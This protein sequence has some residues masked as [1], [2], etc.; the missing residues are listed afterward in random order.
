MAN[1]YDIPA[2]GPSMAFQPFKMN[3]E[4]LGKALLS[5]QQSFDTL[6]AGLGEAKT[7]FAG[8]TASEERDNR[9][10]IN[11]QKELDDFVNSLEGQDLTRVPNLQQQ[12]TA[13]STD[14]NLKIIE[15]N[16]AQNKALQETR[17]EY[18]KDFKY[19][20][21]NFGG[22]LKQK[23]E[24]NAIDDTPEMVS[25]ETPLPYYNYDEELTNSGKL[26]KATV[27]DR[28]ETDPIT[29]AVY[30]NSKTTLNADDIA[31]KL[32]QSFSKQAIQ[33]MSTEYEY[34]PD[35][36]EQF[37]N[38]SDYMLYM[39]ASKA[40]LFTQ[41]KSEYKYV[42][43]DN[44]AADSSRSSITIGNVE[45]D[46]ISSA[47]GSG[48][49][50]NKYNINFDK[51]ID[52]QLQNIV[53]EKTARRDGLGELIKNLNLMPAPNS[54]TGEYKFFDP[55]TGK[56]E[57]QLIES[58]YINSE[59]GED[60]TAEYMNLLHE[61]S[62]LNAE[63]Y[64]INNSQAE[65]K[66]DALKILQEKYKDNFTALGHL[67]K[68][69]SSIDDLYKLFPEKYNKALT[70][71]LKNGDAFGKDAIGYTKNADGSITVKYNQKTNTE[72]ELQTSSSTI[73][74]YEKT[75]T[76]ADSKVQNWYT[77]AEEKVESGIPLLKEYKEAYLESVQD[78][79]TSE[80]VT[81]SMSLFDM[82]D[83]DYAGLVETLNNS[84]QNLYVYS[85]TTGQ[86]VSGESFIKT[87]V[88]GNEPGLDS[89]SAAS[90][91][92]TPKGIYFN[93]VVGKWLVEANVTGLDKDG[94][95][96]IG[97]QSHS[98]FS[99][100][101][102]SFHN[103]ITQSIYGLNAGGV[104]RFTDM[105]VS[106]FNENTKDKIT[107]PIPAQFD[108]T[109]LTVYRDGD[110]YTGTYFDP[111]EGKYRTFT[112][113]SLPDLANRLNTYTSQNT[114]FTDAVRAQNQKVVV[115]YFTKLG[116][117]GIFPQEYLEETLALINHES[118]F[119]TNPSGNNLAA[120]L[121]QFYKDKDIVG[122]K[123][124]KTIGNKKWYLDD[125]RKMSPQEQ[126]NLWWNGYMKPWK[127]KVDK[128]NSNNG[129]GGIILANFVPKWLDLTPE[130]SAIEAIQY[131]KFD[132]KDFA[133]KN[134]IFGITRETTKTLSDQEIRNLLSQYTLQ[135]I[136][137]EV[138]TRWK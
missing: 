100:E 30:V 133:V 57:G 35:L 18:R 94:N 34:N 84:L 15:Y 127:V 29:G 95:R 1:R 79:F 41:S 72:S 76:N 24:Y 80:L 117:S 43:F 7:S 17:E 89:K 105:L 60:V 87:V 66:Q 102:D 125:I 137:D 97:N 2:S 135:D 65:A 129:N 58:A 86:K 136:V 48:F 62:A 27:E 44:D 101:L 23:A 104:D 93:S 19:S 22:V 107:I 53:Q 46:F 92:L 126:A 96:I 39:A 3:T 134:P 122:D 110:T 4:I 6:S 28:F 61:Q 81:S 50:W 90:Y 108:E 73:R 115:D 52:P 83:S 56:F 11:K 121:F 31:R 37:G 98:A 54:R 70:A 20:P 16:N 112:D 124:Y 116:N 68:L 55:L 111:S 45:Y 63:L 71:T 26:L 120:G 123:L 78:A 21:E 14:P 138:Y 99:I 5:R 114:Q 36:Q 10:L 91:E 130:T 42:N 106:S 82:G 25:Y 132:L 109:T 128:W 12:I 33:Q 47:A 131:A 119:N 38:A 74:T 88:D 103:Q 8:L 64:H 75:F 49:L 85:N 40:D 51:A 32:A 77:L 9:Y 113:N 59:T 69:E 13:F 67:D 118:G